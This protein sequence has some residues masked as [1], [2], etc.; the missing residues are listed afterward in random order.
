MTD[1]NLSNL[2]YPIGVFVPPVTITT[3]EI[4]A[5]IDALES[6]PKK[7]SALVKDLPVL[8]LETTYRPGGWTVRQ[9]IHHL[10][11]S[12][13]NSYTRFKWALTEEKPIIKAYDEVR[14]AELF[15][16]KTAPIN[17]SLL[18][19]EAVHAK[20]VYLLRGLTDAELNKCFIHPETQKEVVLKVNI[21]QY[22]WHGNHHVA[23]IEQAL[24]KL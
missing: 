24:K 16:S 23:H 5:W 22:V 12:H 18:H 6:F 17:L 14:W 7:L 4:A 10:A 21:A 3:T 15:D 13:H 2:K 9:V 8:D 20:L 11:D 19:L 1:T